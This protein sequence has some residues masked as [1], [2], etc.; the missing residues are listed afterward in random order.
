MV[1]KTSL[2]LMVLLAMSLIFHLSIHRKSIFILSKSELTMTMNDRVFVFSPCRLAA[3]CGGLSYLC[4]TKKDVVD[5]QMGT[6][7]LR[8][9]HPTKGKWK[10][11][12]GIDS[13]SYTYMGDTN[14]TT[15]IISDVTLA[16]STE[17]V[18]RKETFHLESWIHIGTEFKWS[19]PIPTQTQGFLCVKDMFHDSFKSSSCRTTTTHWNSTDKSTLFPRT[20]AK[21]HSLSFRNEWRWCISHHVIRCSFCKIVFLWWEVFISLEEWCSRWITGIQA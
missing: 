14:V 19:L 13:F 15:L 5:V 7:L 16:C 6:E 11:M 1:G 3:K 10:W 12:V 20:K 18:K 2:S 8:A 9:T 4:C 17:E 21:G